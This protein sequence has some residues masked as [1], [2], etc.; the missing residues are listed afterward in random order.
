MR[1]YAAIGIML[2]LLAAIVLL[3]TLFNSGCNRKTLEEWG[4]MES[5]EEEESDPNASDNETPF[6][7]P[8]EE[9]NAPSW[10]APIVDSPPVLQPPVPNPQPEGPVEIRPHASSFDFVPDD[11]LCVTSF[12]PRKTLMESPAVSS[13]PL[14][15][16]LLELGR[17]GFGIDV[18]SPGRFLDISN[19]SL[20]DLEEVVLIIDGVRTEGVQQVLDALAGKEPELT[21]K[22]RSARAIRENRPNDPSIYGSIVDGYVMKFH[23]PSPQEAIK[24]MLFYTKP[25]YLNGIQY[26]GHGWDTHWGAIYFP[27]PYTIVLGEEVLVRKMI[28]TQ[29]ARPPVDATRYQ[30]PNYDITLTVNWRAL[31]QRL[32][33]NQRMLLRDVML[34]DAV[35]QGQLRVRLSKRPSLRLKI[36]SITS[37]NAEGLESIIRNRMDAYGEGLAT[38]EPWP[39]PWENLR[40]DIWARLNGDLTIEQ[41]GSTLELGLIDSF[42]LEDT[43]DAS[44]RWVAL[45]SGLTPPDEIAANPQ[46]PTTTNET[47]TTPTDALHE[48]SNVRH[49]ILRQVPPTT[50]IRFSEYLAFIQAST[51]FQPHQ[52][53]EQSLSVAL[54]CTWKYEDDIEVGYSE[55]LD[56]F[57]YTCLGSPSPTEILEILGASGSMGYCS[58]IQYD[59]ITNVTC[60][61]EGDVATGV[62]SFNVP[63]LYQGDVLYKAELKEQTVWEIVEFS[64]PNHH[65]TFHR[66][67][68]GFW[69]WTDAFGDASSPDRCP[70]KKRLTGDVTVNGRP[71]KSGQIEFYH[72]AYPEWPFDPYLLFAPIGSF[73]TYK[74]DLPPGNY[75]VRVRGSQDGVPSRYTRLDTARLRVTIPENASGLIGKDFNF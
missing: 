50:G 65:W 17:S 16:I 75:S 14:L 9:P 37:R 48:P 74:I 47:P 13:L 25:V 33:F 2:L 58:F 1:R 45:A 66:D 55:R 19:T 22:E 44:R 8:G 67:A 32:D 21:P 51:P 5:S 46:P 27:D 20:R 40:A 49:M 7:E 54:L 64:L 73:G 23:G 12:T 18:S 42:N 11:A 52:F 71:V 36:D 29:Q 24:R 10:T 6:I 60:N 68:E 59:N 69:R 3:T 56:E 72:E 39:Q 35:E 61:I 41:L 4:L 53:T 70:P 63:R 15:D 34:S 30:D 62:I 31:Y 43:L 57:R 26:Y 38:T 28:Q